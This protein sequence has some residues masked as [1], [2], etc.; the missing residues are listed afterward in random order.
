MSNRRK[1]HRTEAE[2]SGGQPSGQPSG[3]PPASRPTGG[4]TRT[5]PGGLRAAV[6]RVSYPLLVRLHSLPRWLVTG[7][8][9]LLLVAGLL[10]PP[11]YGTVCLALIVAVVGWLT[12]LA[13]HQ[14]ERS[15]RVIR[16]VALALAGGALVLKLV[17]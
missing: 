3:Q 10:A 8:M 9:A 11:P 7:A 4:P 13:W 16:L 2:P 6:E 1:P 17:E 12:Y 5:R 15:R 14:G